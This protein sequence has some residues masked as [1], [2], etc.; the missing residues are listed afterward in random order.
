MILGLCDT[1]RVKKG[2]QKGGQ[3]GGPD[4]TSGPLKSN[5]GSPVS[6]FKMRV[7]NLVIFG[8]SDPFWGVFDPLRCLL[9]AV[10]VTGF[11]PFLTPFGLGLGSSEVFCIH[12]FDY[13]RG[14][15]FDRFWGRFWTLFG[16][17]KWGFLIGV[18][19]GRNRIGIPQ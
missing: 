19:D 9:S 2:G 13:L 3:K 5:R 15:I 1:S 18:Q 12:C 8:H 10:W 7:R 16:G 14:V 11:D 4:T 6:F 17:Q